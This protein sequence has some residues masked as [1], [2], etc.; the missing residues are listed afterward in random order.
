MQ[1]VSVASPV[2]SKTKTGWLRIRL[3]CPNG[4]TCLPS[5]C[6]FS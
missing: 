3:M 4:T 1:F 2:R 5:D 6:C